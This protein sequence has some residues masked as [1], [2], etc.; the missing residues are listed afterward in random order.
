MHRK[1]LNVVKFLKKLLYL[2]FLNISASEN[3]WLDLV[4]PNHQHTLKMGTEFFYRIVEKTSY[5]N[6]A[7]CPRKLRWILSLRMLQELCQ[8]QCPTY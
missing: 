8:C 7:V 1:M 5:L 6:A 3:F 2:R 4:I